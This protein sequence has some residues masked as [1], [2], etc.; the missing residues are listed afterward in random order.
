MH[1]ARLNHVIQDVC[2]SIR[3]LIMFENNQIQNTI[4]CK[5]HVKYINISF[6]CFKYV[7]IL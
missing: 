2:G 6:H 4:F 5:R 3:I 7:S 1:L